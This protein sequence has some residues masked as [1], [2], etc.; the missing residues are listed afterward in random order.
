MV[1]VNKQRGGY[2]VLSS[3]TATGELT[4]DIEEKSID[5][6]RYI[7]FLKKLL[8]GRTRPLI[9]IADNATFRR[10]KEVRAFV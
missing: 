5:G 10:S 7:E 1:T 6:K 9:V 3:I 4:F 8:T 2:N